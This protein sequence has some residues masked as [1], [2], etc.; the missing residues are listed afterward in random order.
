MKVINKHKVK[1]DIATAHIAFW[2]ERYTKLY[3]SFL[4]LKRAEKEDEA[5]SVHSEL[6]HAVEQLS[7]YT[8]VLNNQI[9][10]FKGEINL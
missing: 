8:Q 9:L 10:T 3:R 1:S 5:L 4:K 6:V 2:Q 7:A